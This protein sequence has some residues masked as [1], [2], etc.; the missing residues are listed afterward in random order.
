MQIIPTGSHPD[1]AEEESKQFPIIPLLVT[2]YAV[3]VAWAFTTL[4]TSDV[5]V[6]NALCECTPTIMPVIILLTP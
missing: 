4:S 2:V 6:V 1:V 3:L 5:E